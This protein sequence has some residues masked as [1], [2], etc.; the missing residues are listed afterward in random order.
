MDKFLKEYFNEINNFLLSEKYELA[1]IK[2]DLV[3]SNK[4]SKRTRVLDKDD[5][6]GGDI[7]DLDDIT[8]KVKNEIIVNDKIKPRTKRKILSK[9]SKLSKKTIVNLYDRLKK[10]KKNKKQKKE[11]KKSI[12][13]DEEKKSVLSDNDKKETVSNKKNKINNIVSCEN[14]IKDFEKN[15]TNLQDTIKTMGINN[16][17]DC[18]FLMKNTKV[19]NLKVESLKNI[20]DKTNLNNI[21]ERLKISNDNAN[22]IKKLLDKNQIKTLKKLL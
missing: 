2:N 16:I 4:N 12:P 15:I 14:F 13:K 5:L 22:N 21:I 18:I 3:Q 10:L 17:M 7:I 11:S 20:D 19:E 1:T 8:K 6:N 9:L